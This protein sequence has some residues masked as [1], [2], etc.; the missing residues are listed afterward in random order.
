[1]KTEN[2]VSWKNEPVF[3]VALA[4]GISC[5]VM[6]AFVL[7]LDFRRPF[8]ERILLL[9]P[10]IVLS[11][12]GLLKT[13]F[14]N[15]Y[16]N[17][18]LMALNTFIF[19]ACIELIASAIF[20]ADVLLNPTPDDAER[21]AAQPYYDTISW[22]DSYWEEFERLGLRYAP[23]VVWQRRAFHGTQININENG[24]RDTPGSNCEIENAYR[25]FMFGGSTI[26]GTGSPDSATI[27]A[28]I[29]QALNQHTER[30][31]CV[32]NFGETAYVAGQGVIRL[33]Q[34]L[35]AENI[36]DL[37]IFYDGINDVFAAYQ[38]HQTGV[39]MNM[40]QISSRF[41]NRRPTLSNVI[42]NFQSIELMRKAFSGDDITGTT[43]AYDEAFAAEIV[44][45]YLNYQRVV[46]ALA[47][48]YDFEVQFFWQ[49]VIFTGDKPLTSDE[50]IIR[51]EQEARSPGVEKLY[52]DAVAFADSVD[53]NRFHVIADTF[54]SQS[55]QIWID[56]SHVTP[57]GNRLVAARMLEFIKID[58][59]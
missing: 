46:N 29:Q 8:S 45:D 30:A 9:L 58:D 57:E 48:E 26:W 1:M 15:F 33:I 43:Y 54:D 56:F 12:A 17:A 44:R 7:V 25:V 37:V 24:I 6:A 13:R 5:L 59:E 19:L 10:G 35:H 14:V 41:E 53:N 3:C 34:E 31:V 49:P 22:S 42:E 52:Q 32:I 36:P 27:P 55:Q 23:Y 51:R 50:K 18:A 4:V 21:M 11:G 47:V 39:H 40:A 16:R 38:S 2:P 20:Q 28:F